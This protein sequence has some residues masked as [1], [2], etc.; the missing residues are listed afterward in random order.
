MERSKVK[1]YICAGVLLVVL[2][3]TLAT[4]IGG[5]GSQAVV[6]RP[7]GAIMAV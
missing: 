5:S 3:V 7:D 2:I 6:V 1:S 4:V